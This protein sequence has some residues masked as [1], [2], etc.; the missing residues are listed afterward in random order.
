MADGCAARARCRRRPGASPAWPARPSRRANRSGTV[1]VGA[2]RS[3]TTSPSSASSCGC[4]ATGAGSASSRDLAARPPAPAPRR[5]GEASARTVSRPSVPSCGCSSPCGRADDV[6]RPSSRDLARPADG[7]RAL[8]PRDS[9][10]SRCGS[11]ARS[12]TLL[13]GASVGAAATGVDRRAR[14]CACGR[15]PR[16]PRLETLVGAG[17][18]VR[19]PVAG[20]ERPAAPVIAAARRASVGRRRTAAWPAALVQRLARWPARRARRPVALA[21]RR[22]SDASLSA[23]C[24]VGR[25]SAVVRSR[26]AGGAALARCDAGPSWLERGRARCARSVATRLAAPRATDGSICS[27]GL[28][29]ATSASECL[30]EQ[31]FETTLLSFDRAPAVTPRS[32]RRSQPHHCRSA[33]LHRAAARRPR[34]RHEAHTEDQTVER[35]KALEMALGQ[36][37]KQFG[38]GSV[39]KMGE[40]GDDGD[41]GRSPPAPSPSTSPSA[42]AACPG[43]GSSRSSARS[44]RASPPSPCTSW[45]RPSA[46]AASA[47][48][49]TPST[50]W[51]R[52]TPRP[53]AS[54]STSCSSPSPTRASRR[55][56]SPT[57]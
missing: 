35:E 24:T 2:R 5:R 7:W 33:D 52:S 56:R 8:D 21:G 30:I 42:S 26:P 16:R 12:T 55:S 13:D 23:R 41:R 29:S 38:K 3:A 18:V 19:C 54:T 11:S 10:T 14:S 53:S 50:P 43:A 20:L 25:R 1:F 49:S 32:S 34:R 48:T 4:R 47:P 39:M 15:R 27:L 28:A 44:R 51:T 40:K 17:C 45:P 22:P 57:C 37:E 36:I 6:A 46:T 9:G 31:A